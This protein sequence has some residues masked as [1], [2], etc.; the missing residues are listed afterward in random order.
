MDHSILF[1]IHRLVLPVPS[2]ECQHLSSLG[3]AFA[4]TT[5]SGFMNV[6]A[7]LE[8]ESSKIAYI[9]CLN[10]FLYL[11]WACC[12]PMNYFVFIR[13]QVGCLLVSTPF[14]IIIIIITLLCACA[15]WL[16]PSNLVCTCSS[17]IRIVMRIIFTIIFL[18]ATL[19][20]TWDW[21]CAIYPLV[22]C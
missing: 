12:L 20:G 6:P 8:P 18:P 10:S 3:L 7:L 14:I 4:T 1:E 13:V 2:I 15:F 21:S 11:A 22:S 16:V 5:I 9:Y 17:I 19:K